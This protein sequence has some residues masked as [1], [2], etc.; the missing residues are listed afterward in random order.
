MNFIRGTPLWQHIIKVRLAHHTLLHEY[1]WIPFALLLPSVLTERIKGGKSHIRHHSDIWS[2]K[3]PYPI[4]WDP[5][6]HPGTRLRLIIKDGLRVRFFLSAS[7]RWFRLA[8]QRPTCASNWRIT[9][10]QPRSAKK[11]NRERKMEK[12]A[13]WKYKHQSSSWF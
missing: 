1:Q 7:S 13:S 4:H 12:R 10:M 6:N 9:N 2:R 11:K 5:S 8:H 3:K